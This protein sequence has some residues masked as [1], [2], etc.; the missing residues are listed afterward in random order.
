MR[1]KC[2]M[3][4]QA[5]L[6][7]KTSFKSQKPIIVTGRRCVWCDS[8]CKEAA[9]KCEPLDYLLWLRRK[10]CM[11]FPQVPPFL[12]HSWC[13]RTNWSTVGCGF[14]SSGRILLVGTSPYPFMIATRAWASWVPE[15]SREGRTYNK[16]KGEPRGTT[17]DCLAG[18]A[19]DCVI[20]WKS[21][22][23]TFLALDICLM[24]LAPDIFWSQRLDTLFSPD[25]LF[26]MSLLS[27]ETDVVSAAFRWRLFLLASLALDISFFWDL[28]LLTFSSL[29][30]S[31][32][33]HGFRLAPFFLFPV[34]SH[35]YFETSFC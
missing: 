18:T 28:L 2:T 13:F 22:S 1:D 26:L 24:R 19:V 16:D 5:Y 33:W 30:I 20:S 21:L 14:C 23:L 25:K 29:H 34:V 4:N 27:L 8:Q 3:K 9:D 6:P 7:V 12:I 11:G 17:P 31:F 15:V 35:F 32:S 10:I